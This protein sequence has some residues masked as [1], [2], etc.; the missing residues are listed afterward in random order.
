M[1]RDDVL[2]MM[3][4]LKLRGMSAVYDEVLSNGRTRRLTPEKVIL[5]LLRAESAERR[6]RSIRYRMGMARFPLLKDLDL[7]QR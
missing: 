5:E 6:M 7:I 2:Q 3:D 1:L 4:T